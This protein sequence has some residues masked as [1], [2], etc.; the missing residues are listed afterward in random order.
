MQTFPMV[1]AQDVHARMEH[2]WKRNCPTVEDVFFQH[3][4]TTTMYQLKNIVVIS[5]Q[6]P[7]WFADIEWEIIR[8]GTTLLQRQFILLH[9]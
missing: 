3:P 6:I 1:K 5:E 9:A 4:E 2:I 7:M 8:S